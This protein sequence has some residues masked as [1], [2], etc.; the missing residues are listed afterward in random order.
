MKRLLKGI[1]YDL[2]NSKPVLFITNAYRFRRILSRHRWWDYTFTLELLQKS[3]QIVS[4]GIETKG[5]EIDDYRLK[6]VKAMKRCIELLDNK[7]ND[8][9]LEQAEKQLG[10][11]IYGGDFFEWDK[12][13]PEENEHNKNVSRLSFQIEQSE[14]DELWDTIKGS[15]SKYEKWEAFKRKQFTKEQRKDNG[16]MESEYRKWYDGSGMRSWW[17]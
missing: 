4:N 7:L 12:L 6:K 3:L 8:R 10:K 2:L 15:S 11:Y 9:Y 16:L 1:K 13:T 17:D 14:W 5:N